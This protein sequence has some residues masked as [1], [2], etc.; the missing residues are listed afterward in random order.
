MAPVLK[1]RDRLALFSHALLPMSLSLRLLPTLAL[2]VLAAAPAF[3]LGDV[4]AAGPITAL[5]DASVS[6]DG[7]T[8]VLTADTEVRDDD[9]DT[10][11]DALAV[12]LT[13]EIR[14][15]ADAEGTLTA[16]RIEIQDDGDD[17]VRLEG[18]ITERGDSAVRVGAVWVLVTDATR[19]RDDEGTAAFDDLLVGLHVEVRGTVDSTGQVVA[20]RVEIDERD[21]DDSDDEDAEVKGPIE[22]LGP[23]S[24]TVLGRTFAVTEATRIHDGATEVAFESLIVGQLVEVHGAYAADGSLV[25]TRIEV[26]DFADDEVELTG[27]IEALEAD[28]L[29]VAGL[30]F[31]VTAATIVLDD[32]R[33]PI[34]FASL[35][36]GQFVEIRADVV[37][38]GVRRATHIKVE[39]ILD[40][41][42]EVTAV[43]DA[44]GD[45]VVVLLGRAFAT[46]STTVMPAGLAAG[47]VVE[48]HAVIA[49]GGD[50]RATRIERE[51]RSATRVELRGPVTGVGT[52]S[53][54]V[55]EVPFA[56]DA[57]TVFVG[58][59]GTPTTLDAISPGASV[60]VWADVTDLGWLATRIEVRATARA[61]GLATGVTPTGFR[62]GGVTVHVTPATR[63]VSASGAPRTAI[64]SGETVAAIGTSGADGVLAT[65]VVV[66]SEA[67]AVATE[68]GREAT[69][70]ALA[71]APNP[72]AGIGRLRYDLATAAE[73]E[74]VVFSTL[75]R[76]VTR[77]GA[78]MQ[79]AGSHTTTLDLS[80]LPSGVYLVRMV[81]DGRAAGGPLALTVAR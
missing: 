17:E 69:V 78:A 52:D 33:L 15:D 43:L 51:D 20:D 30:R 55:I 58:R 22:D 38:S 12:G 11:V 6:V 26:E 73:V 35:V 63:I 66:L 40:D 57:A 42:V 74:I 18:P 65:R 27:A 3:A 10:T 79:S 32:A 47:D 81:V 5:S 37:A 14:G 70:T 9:G 29:T 50:L 13:V 25:A 21:D 77:L 72:L 16:T 76:E 64:A 2:L 54:A 8:F 61:T 23:A 59:D 56:V 31:E 53:L 49:P 7:L 1:G 46:D 39:D 34:P 48:F 75:G 36:V 67:T 62:V 44:V 60:E 68:T 80:G 24:L 28:A 4:E 71:V 45:G 41:E 19:I